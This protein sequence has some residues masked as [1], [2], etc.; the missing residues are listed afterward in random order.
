MKTALEELKEIISNKLE[1]FDKDD[2]NKIHKSMI[3]VYNDVLHHIKQLE[4]KE[5]QYLIDAYDQGDYNGILYAQNVD[6]RWD[7]GEDY[8]KQTFKQD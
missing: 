2:S 6:T 4:E 3:Y 8:F 5:K 1:A 7:C